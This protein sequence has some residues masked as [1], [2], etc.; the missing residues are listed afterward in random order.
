MGMTDDFARCTKAFAIAVALLFTAGI[1]FAQDEPA[2]PPPL[3]IEPGTF[4]T[5][6]MN[7]AVSSDRNQVGDAFSATLTQPL[8]VQGIVIAQRGQ[9][10]GG[11]VI[12]A[13]RAGMVS[14]VSRLGIELTR[15]TLA[16]G[17]SIPIRTH[18][19]ARNGRAEV[20]RDVATIVGTT[21]VGAVI[22]G[23]AGRGRGAAIGAGVGA[24]AGTVGVLLSRGYPAI[25]YPESMLTFEVVAPVAI[26]TSNAPQAFRAVNSGDY[27]RTE[28]QLAYQPAPVY[29]PAPLPP[30]VVYPY[31]Y[32]YAPPYYPYYPYYARPYYYGP[33]VS[34]LF[35]SPGYYRYRPHN[36]YVYRARPIP[37]R[38]GPYRGV[39]YRPAPYRHVT[40]HG[41]GIGHGRR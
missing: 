10:V 28:A 21:G 31:P 39:P 2:G 16:D 13:K 29:G 1:G 30:P 20:G 7:E 25:V 34:F 19:L 11:H 9:T 17:Q 23:I 38:A 3:S 35:G 18:L 27:Q 6:R 15:L 14:G 5:V 40:P 26:D 32:V 22:G 41:R 24:A 37:Y 36:V 33:S 8:I 4:L 12:E